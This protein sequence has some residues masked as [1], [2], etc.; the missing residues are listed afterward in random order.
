ME[1]G[2]GHDKLASGCREQC[3]WAINSLSSLCQDCAADP[4]D[5]DFLQRIADPHAAGPSS[6]QE[7][8]YT[9]MLDPCLR[10]PTPPPEDCHTSG[11]HSPLPAFMDQQLTARE[12]SSGPAPVVPYGSTP[13]RGSP[14]GVLAVL[15][16]QIC[17]LRLRLG[18]SSELVGLGDMPEYP[19]ELPIELC[20]QPVA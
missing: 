11:L 4:L 5:P 7:G 2:A 19:L 16:C 6:S 18:P 13:P 1:P 3:G 8:V 10:S 14:A 17:S 20:V 15:I 12:S 9:L